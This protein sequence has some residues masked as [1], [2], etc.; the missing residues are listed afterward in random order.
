MATFPTYSEYPV[1]PGYPGHLAHLGHPAPGDQ[2]P[3]LSC[4]STSPAVMLV[5]N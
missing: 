2:G 3:M 1:H 4:Q 5:R